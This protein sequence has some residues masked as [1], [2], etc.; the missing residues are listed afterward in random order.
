[1]VLAVRLLLYFCYLAFW[2]SFYFSKNY[3][4]Q[5]TAKFAKEVDLEIEKIYKQPT[6]FPPELYL[7]T[8]NNLYRFAIVMKSW[9]IIFKVT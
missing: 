9:K 6:A 4:P 3:S 7:S 5:N 2:Y 8:K 1:M